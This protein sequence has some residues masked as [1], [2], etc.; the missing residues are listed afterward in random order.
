MAV[1]VTVSQI[2]NTIDEV[3]LSQR[4]FKRF[5]RWNRH[6]EE[7]VDV[8]VLQKHRISSSW[9]SNSN[10]H[11]QQWFN[12]YT[13]SSYCFVFF[14]FLLMLSTLS[15]TLPAFVQDYLRWFEVLWEF[16]QQSLTFREILRHDWWF[17]E[18]LP[19]TQLIS[20]LFEVFFSKVHWSVLYKFAFYNNSSGLR[21]TWRRLVRF[22]LFISTI[23]N[24]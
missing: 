16:V 7:E 24:W 6:H 22:S 1:C 18:S 20:D 2:E 19:I 23:R 14:A 9:Q 21:E 11:R 12:C 15:G 10:Q 3:R 5:P 8:Q 17:F 4:S 13:L